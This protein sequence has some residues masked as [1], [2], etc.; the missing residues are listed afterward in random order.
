MRYMLSESGASVAVQMTLFLR[1]K[2][3]VFSPNFSLF[4]S[5]KRSKQVDDLKK[6]GKT[7][8]I[9]RYV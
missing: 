8:K 9:G 5:D 4:Y 3:A 6:V 1:G 2:I 7:D